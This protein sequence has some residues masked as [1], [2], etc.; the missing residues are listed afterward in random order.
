MNYDNIIG[1]TRNLDN[2]GRVV[3]PMELRKSLGFAENQGVEILA[4]NDHIIIRK[5]STRCIFCG[6]PT[7]L[8]VLSR[9]ACKDCLE[10]LQATSRNSQP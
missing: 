5:A 9:Y 2:L 4:D 7:E 6:E 1:I 10:K 8:Q 3:I